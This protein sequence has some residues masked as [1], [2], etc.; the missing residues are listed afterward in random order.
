M[1]C[2]F[3]SVFSWPY[4]P[5]TAALFLLVAVAV[6]RFCACGNHLMAA[7][8]FPLGLYLESLFW[9]LISLAFR[10]RG[11][12]SARFRTFAERA[13]CTLDQWWFLE[14][15]QLCL[16]TEL[17]IVSSSH[18]KCQLHLA[19]TVGSSLFRKRRATCLCTSGDIYLAR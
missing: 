6:R 19:R 2:R 13:R 12:I 8:F 15:F 14:I 9:S 11:G 16:E 4:S 10:P 7:P 3:A 5:R 1:K 18:R 17:F